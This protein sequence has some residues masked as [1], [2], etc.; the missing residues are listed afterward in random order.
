MQPDLGNLQLRNGAHNTRRPAG[1]LCTNRTTANRRSQ[2]RRERP[3]GRLDA[4]RSEPC[5]RL[6][7][8]ARVAYNLAAFTRGPT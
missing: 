4:G 3:A 1:P 5:R 7:R 2:A 8:T 6:A